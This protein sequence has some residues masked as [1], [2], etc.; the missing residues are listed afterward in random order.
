ML[1]VK[2][3][4]ISYLGQVFW[5]YPLPDKKHYKSHYRLIKSTIYYKIFKPF[6][7]MI[8]LLHL[9]LFPPQFI[10]YKII[11]II[12]FDLAGIWQEIGVI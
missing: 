6:L 8:I 3:L 12:M 5:L 9:Q 11:E 10:K 4:G 2:D 7:L 1:Q